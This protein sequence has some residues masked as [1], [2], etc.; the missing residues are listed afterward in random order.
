MSAG[1]YN[2]HLLSSLHKLHYPI[3]LKNS[4]QIKRSGGL[5]RGKDDAIDA[6]RIAHY[7]F[8]FKDKIRIWPPP[9]IIQQLA[10]LSAL[11]DRLF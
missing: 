2:A 5:Q 7:A 6:V 11:R 4:L 8:R 10:A 9:Q 3:W 1:I